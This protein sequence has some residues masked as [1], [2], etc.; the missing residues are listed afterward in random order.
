MELCEGFYSLGTYSVRFRQ[1]PWETQGGSFPKAQVV[2]S[3]A[4]PARGGKSGCICRRHSDSIQR[5]LLLYITLR[6][7]KIF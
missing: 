7:Q 4:Y 2:A 5:K 6:K 3:T 1:A